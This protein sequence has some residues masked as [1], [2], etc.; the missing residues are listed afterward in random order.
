MVEFREKLRNALI[1]HYDFIKSK[2]NDIYAYSLYTD[3]SLCSIGPVFN[4]ESDLKVQKSEDLY[5]Y[6]RYG[7]VEWNHYED[8]GIF[9]EVNNLLI[10]I[11][12]CDHP[13]WSERRSKVLEN[14]LEVLCSLENHDFFGPKNSDRFVVICIPDSDD[15]IMDKSAKLLNSETNYNL[16]SKEF[17]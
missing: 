13:E 14:C 10:E 6:Y 4:C 16:Y 7:A 2:H 8:F 5:N 12:N 3:S 1:K 15:P 9:D 17:S 11:M